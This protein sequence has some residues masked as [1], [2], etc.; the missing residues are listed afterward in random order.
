MGVHGGRVLFGKAPFLPVETV[1]AVAA[2][3]LA[4]MAPLKVVL[5]SE[6]NKPFFTEVKVIGIKV[7]AFAR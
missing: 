3:A 6:N 4:T 1:R 2:A 5:F 7:L